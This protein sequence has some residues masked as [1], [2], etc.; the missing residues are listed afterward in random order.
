VKSLLSKQDFGT[1]QECLKKLQKKEMTVEQLLSSLHGLFT[2]GIEQ[3]SRVKEL[4][5][6]FSDFLPKKHVSK[7]DKY[8]A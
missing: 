2:K 4:M 8:I 5:M 1:F 6:G 3:E 7:L